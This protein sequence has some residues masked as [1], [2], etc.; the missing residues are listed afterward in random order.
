M[1]I[2]W[3]SISHWISCDLEPVITRV[4]LRCIYII[5]SIYQYANFGTL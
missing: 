2:Q 4:R 5:K 1:K 3:P